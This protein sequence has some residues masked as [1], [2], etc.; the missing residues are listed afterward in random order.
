M[1][2]QRKEDEELLKTLGSKA[3]LF[4]ILPECAY[5]ER[6]KIHREV[7]QPPASLFIPIGFN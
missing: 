1:E 7:N 5:D 3:N 4:Y 6:L 2:K